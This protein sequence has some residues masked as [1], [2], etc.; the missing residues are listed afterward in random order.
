MVWRN[1][2]L[3]DQKSMLDDDNLDIWTY[4]RFND[5]YFLDFKDPLELFAKQFQYFNL[6]FPKH[7]IFANF[8]CLRCG[9]CC[10]HYRDIAY[11]EDIKRWISESRYDILRYVECRKS[12]RGGKCAQF[13]LHYEFEP[14]EDCKGG[15]ILPNDSGKCP[16]LRKVKGK[17]YYTCLIHDTPPKECSEFIC[18][19]SLPISHLKWAEIDEL[20]QK[21]GVRQWKKLTR[22]SVF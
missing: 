6:R 4:S 20:I 21:I 7:F 16:F 9:D 8:Q 11:R 2:M 15:Y 1:T 17:P 3:Y 12:E 13:F 18:N 14:C 5:D 10:M 19:K 22:I